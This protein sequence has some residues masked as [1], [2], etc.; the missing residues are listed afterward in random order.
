[1][2]ITALNTQEFGQDLAKQALQYIPSDI[3]EEQKKYIADK[4]FQFSI[5]AGNHLIEKFNDQFDDGQAKVVIQ[6]IGEWTFHKGVDL[7]RAKVPSEHWDGLLQQI[8]FSSLQTAIQ[9]HLEKQDTNKIA[10]I[11]ENQVAVTYEALIKDLAKTG[12]IKDED[13]QS[14][15]TESNVDKMAKETEGKV[16]NDNEETTLK[17]AALAIILKKL[18]PEKAES[19]MNTFGEEERLKI[20]QYLKIDNIEQKLD[21]S[22]INQYLSELKKVLSVISKPN[23]IELIKSIKNLGAKH[24]EENLINTVS[25]ERLKV[26]NY[27]E[28]CLFDT[29]SKTLQL[30]FSPYIAKI[31]YS[32]LQEKLPIRI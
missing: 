10:S 2:A 13:I 3:S 18:R 8:A 4:V 27:I 7:I 29:T 28:N 31:L 19:I 9:C 1:M 6:F 21:P 5:I 17:Y 16:P 24:R 26:L 12:A 20:D 11:I 25:Y 32:Y 22:L 14:I 23:S 15:I 30:E